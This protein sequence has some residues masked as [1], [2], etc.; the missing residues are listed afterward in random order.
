VAQVPVDFPVADE[1]LAELATEAI[2][3][4]FRLMFKRNQVNWYI[5]IALLPGQHSR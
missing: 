5:H 2:R 1:V 4:G 3:C